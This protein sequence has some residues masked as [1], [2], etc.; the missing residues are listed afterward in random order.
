MKK[1]VKLLPLGLLASSIVACSCKREEPVVESVLEESKNIFEGTKTSMKLST[2]EVYEYIRENNSNDVKRVF[3]QYLMESI[4]DLS[5]NSTN[6]TCGTSNIA[7]SNI[8]LLNGSTNIHIKYNI[9]IDPNNNLLAL[10]NGI[11]TLYKT[12]KQAKAATTVDIVLILFVKDKLV[13][14]A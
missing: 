9:N 12:I 6:K 8:E 13:S 4:L 10:V 2:Q 1:I 7:N 5:N 3:L 14:N 11:H